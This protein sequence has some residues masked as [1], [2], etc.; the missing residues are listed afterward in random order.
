MT[1]KFTFSALGTTWWIE[2][3]DQLEAERLTI[4]FDDCQAFVSAF[5]N[6]YSR[7][8]ADSLISKLNTNRVFQNPSKEFKEI[9]SY[10]KSMYVRSNTHFNLL[11]GHIQEAN[12]YDAEYSFI[13][14]ETAPAAGNP[15]TD[16]LIAEDQIELLGDSNI[17]FGGFGKGFLVDMLA[18]RLQTEH[19]C[20][21]FLINGGGDIFVTSNNDKPITIYL[22]H[23]TK[24]KTG[25][26]TTPLKNQ[27]FASSSPFK[28][29]WKTSNG[30]QSHIIGE[31]RLTSFIKADS[32]ADA[33]VF[34][35]VSLLMN[36]KELTEFAKNESFSYALYSPEENKKLEHKEFQDI[37][38]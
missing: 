28:R 37:N 19:G 27:A 8:K 23:P 20:E 30:T 31:T 33:D 29:T 3:F 35:T 4:I 22:E 18:K 6:N 15:I 5:E 32:A 2:I 1:N 24:E 12:G 13:G 10:G 38:S 26:G 21:F 14:T 36:N 25:I 11:T 7:F 16:L 17:D 34:A 9:L